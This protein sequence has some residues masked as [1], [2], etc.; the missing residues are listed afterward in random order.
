MW[1]TAQA[2][3]TE[4]LG[5]GRMPCF[6]EMQRCN[7]HVH[8]LIIRHSEWIILKVFL[9]SVNQNLAFKCVFTKLIVL[10]DGGLSL[11]LNCT[12]NQSVFL[13]S[14]TFY[15]T[16]ISLVSHYLELVSQISASIF[17]MSSSWHRSHCRF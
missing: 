13:N 6:M 5:E 2:G 9:S 17:K 10:A 4:C 3:N 11:N 14:I 8:R 1:H 16:D 12:V 7:F 15:F